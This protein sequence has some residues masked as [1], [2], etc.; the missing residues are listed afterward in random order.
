MRYTLTH[1]SFVGVVAALGVLVAA[2]T[3]GASVGPRVIH[4]VLQQPDGTRHEFWGGSN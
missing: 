4:G 1:K 3:A 2:A